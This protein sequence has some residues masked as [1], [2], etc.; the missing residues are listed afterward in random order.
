MPSGGYSILPRKDLT[1]PFALMCL[2]PFKIPFP[3]FC[4]RMTA[5]A[6]QKGAQIQVPRRS[7]SPLA[8][9]DLHRDKWTHYPL[10]PEAIKSHGGCLVKAL[11]DISQITYDL[12][13]L[14]FGDKDRKLDTAFAQATEYVHSRLNRWYQ[15]LP[16]C[17]G[18][19]NAPPHVLSLQCVLL[20]QSFT[21]QIRD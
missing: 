14:L 4:Y 11:C 1:P 5:L 20:L 18:T 6:Y 21:P 17:L 12:S 19:T 10:S 8:N 2:K 3:Y 16:K 15:E 9:C 7:Y 13:W